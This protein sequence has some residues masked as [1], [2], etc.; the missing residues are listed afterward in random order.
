MVWKWELEK[1]SHE[2]DSAPDFDL[3]SSVILI[4]FIDVFRYHEKKTPCNAPLQVAK[5]TYTE[6]RGMFW[7]PPNKRPVKLRDSLK[8]LEVSVPIHHF[9]IVRE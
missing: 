4:Y 7:I 1:I 8:E 5:K 9:T 2:L 6:K 3:I